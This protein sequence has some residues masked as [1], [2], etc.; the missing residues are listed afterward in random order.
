MIIHGNKQISGI[1]YARKASDGGG[2]VALTNIIRGPQVVFG[3]LE[4]TPSRN[5]LLPATMQAILA[6]FG[7]RDGMAVIKATNRYLNVLNAT[8]QSKAQAL[9]GFINEDPMMVCSLGLEP[10]LTVLPKMPIRTVNGGGTGYFRTGVSNVPCDTTRYV[11]K[12][13][14]TATN[15]QVSMGNR[16]SYSSKAFVFTF[17]WNSA[18][19]CGWNYGNGYVAKSGNS[20]ALDVMHTF[21]MDGTTGKVLVDGAEFLSRGVATGVTSQG[22]FLLIGVSWNASDTATSIGKGDFAGGEMYM[23][24]ALAHWHVPIKR[25][26]AMEMLDVITGNLLERV[27]T[28]TEGFGYNQNGQWVTWTPAT[29]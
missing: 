16:L 28:F 6:A 21:D 7:Q 8:D 10:E 9:A 17:T 3:G 25:N 1:I 5:W 18:G 13:R 14:R 26:G 12:Y 11:Y 20:I 15:D 24:G 19:N 29:P 4:P 22:Q 2:A 27:G 23:Q